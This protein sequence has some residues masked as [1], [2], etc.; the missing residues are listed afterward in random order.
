MNI[1]VY[2]Q[3]KLG[4]PLACV[5]AEAGHMVYGVDVSAEVVA[6]LREG[7]SHIAEPGFQEL[8]LDVLAM[9]TYLPTTDQ[10]GFVGETDAAFVLV[11][12]PSGP[13][14]QFSLDYVLQVIKVIGLS[15]PKR[16]SSQPYLV[17]IVSTVMPGSMEIIKQRLGSWS[18]MKEGRDFHLA[19]NPEFVALGNVIE[20]LREP[21]A[22]LIG[23][24][25]EAQ[26]LL[27]EDIYNTFVPRS[28]PVYSMSWEE[29][30]LAKLVLNCYLSVK[31]SFANY[32]GVLAGRMGLSADTILKFIGRDPRIGNRFF[33]PGLPPG[34]TCLPR[35]L[36]AVRS[37]TAKKMLPTPFLL[38]SIGPEGAQ[39]LGEVVEFLCS[40]NAYSFGFV[41]I[42]YKPDTDVLEASPPIAL[43][44][45][46]HTINPLAVL[47]FYD[48]TRQES[49]TLPFDH[50][51]PYGDGHMVFGQKTLEALVSKAEV[52]V[53]TIPHG[54]ELHKLDIEGKIVVDLTGALCWEDFPSCDFYSLK[55]G[56]WTKQP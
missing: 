34:G 46:L 12:T 24:G 19:Y 17:T 18:G 55:E 26:T 33:R 30:E 7:K 40:L 50:A 47:H 56:L 21:F 32:I 51:R 15:L 14:G 36:R 39:N 43:I 5:L 29:A 31:V 45:L 49:I 38:N 8:L 53:V 3:G 25:F 11:P 16:R 10:Y 27:V 23:G 42:T 37:Y 44:E 9:G 20:G 41:G 22:L 54:N 2:G 48:P 1:I 52:V 28:V 6:M 4:A 13:D 35:D